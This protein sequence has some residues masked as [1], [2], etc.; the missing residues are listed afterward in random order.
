MFIHRED[1]YTTR[2]EWERK[3]PAEG[4][5]ENIAEIMVAKHRNGP[6][7][8]VQLYFRNDR[9]RFETLDAPLGERE[10]EP[11]W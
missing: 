9:V 7:G 3:H 5:P 6:V 8:T 11:A 1:R 10:M 4:Y 2:E